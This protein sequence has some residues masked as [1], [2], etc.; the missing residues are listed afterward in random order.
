MEDY[1]K[2][3]E[4]KEAL[5]ARL[6]G[7]TIQDREAETIE[8]NPTLLAE[9]YLVGR[10]KY[11]QARNFGFNHDQALFLAKNTNHANIKTIH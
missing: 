9:A 2:T 5:K 1:K 6:C 11:Q 4:Y 10:G 7:I 8:D 3:P